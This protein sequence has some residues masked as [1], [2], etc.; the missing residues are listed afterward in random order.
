MTVE[1]LGPEAV[2][3]EA[4]GGFVLGPQAPAQGCGPQRQ[5]GGVAL[6]TLLHAGARR[7]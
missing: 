5:R 4:R 7:L 6:R 1:E 2:E 3:Q